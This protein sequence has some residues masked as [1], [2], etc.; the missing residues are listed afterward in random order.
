[1][2]MS[3]SQAS[4]SPS[5]PGRNGVRGMRAPCGRKRAGIHRF[6]RQK[7]VRSAVRLRK[8]DNVVHNRHCRR[9]HRIGAI[10]DSIKRFRSRLGS[11][12]RRHQMAKQ[13]QP[14]RSIPLKISARQ[15][16][17][18]RRIRM[19]ADKHVRN[20]RIRHDVPQNRKLKRHV[21]KLLAVPRVPVGQLVLE[22]RPHGAVPGCAGRNEYRGMCRG[23]CIAGG[24][25]RGEYEGKESIAGRR[26]HRLGMVR[27][28]QA[29]RI[30]RSIRYRGVQK[31]THV[32][33]RQSR[34]H[35]SRKHVLRCELGTKRHPVRMRQWVIRTP[36]RSP[37]GKVLVRKVHVAVV[38]HERVLVVRR[39]RRPIRHILRKQIG[40]RIGVA[41]IA[42]FVQL[43][44]VSATGKDE[45]E[46]NKKT[47]YQRVR[48]VLRK[49]PVIRRRVR[50]RVRRVDR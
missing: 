49:L 14:S 33:Q 15:S 1:M 35:K 36:H 45:N 5:A 12:N 37:I 43:E 23:K 48:I 22:Q 10:A 8:L 2:C 21:V 39:R 30:R 26:A 47:N 44:W 16:R 4:S 25:E 50:S 13:H 38:H 31:R 41:R 27:K 42:P 20:T 24:E 28:H 7:G 3:H 40:Y 18:C 29:V 11:S 19:V 32:F 46:Y 9:C 6:K 34:Q 17:K